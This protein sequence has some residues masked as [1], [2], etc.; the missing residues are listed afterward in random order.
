MPVQTVETVSGIVWSTT[1]LKQGV[2][3]RVTS[4]G[5]YEESKT[6]KRHNYL[7]HLQQKWYFL[8]IKLKT[9]KP[10]KGLGM[11]RG[12]YEK[13]LWKFA[14]TTAKKQIPFVIIRE[15]RNTRQGKK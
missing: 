11:R 8:Y 9:I 10:R 15:E 13:S 3:E 6:N 4:S 14:R 1:P 5:E 7:I 12:F 2:N